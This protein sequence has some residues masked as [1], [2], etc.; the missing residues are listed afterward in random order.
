MLIRW[1]QNDFYIISS[2][3]DKHGS[4]VYLSFHLVCVIQSKKVDCQFVS[5]LRGPWKCHVNRESYQDHLSNIRG[6][7]TFF[8]LPRSFLF[9]CADMSFLDV[10]SWFIH[11][12]LMQLSYMYKASNIKQVIKSK[13]IYVLSEIYVSWREHSCFEERFSLD[14]NQISSKTT[15]RSE[16]NELRTSDN[17]CSFIVDNISPIITLS[18]IIFIS[19]MPWR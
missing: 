7:I 13:K 10:T 18:I 16:K 3:L 5:E 15:N 2:T 6:R 11:N 1:L 17:E 14:G 9:S 4:N 19:I 12:S 8:R